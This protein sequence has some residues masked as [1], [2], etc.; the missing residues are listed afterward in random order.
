MH[1]SKNT[2]I[3]VSI[4]LITIKG[5]ENGYLLT[6]DYAKTLAATGTG[7]LIAGKLGYWLLAGIVAVTI[8][9]A[10]FI[11]RTYFPINK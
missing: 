5:W 4:T 2:D 10:A 6:M 1:Y 3:L 8:I 9:L 7:V 11:I